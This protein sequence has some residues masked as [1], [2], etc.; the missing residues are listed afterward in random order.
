MS[1]IRLPENTPVMRKDQNAPEWQRYFL[2]I[3]NAC[4]AGYQSVVTADRPTSGLWDGRICW[5]R[6]L[7]KPIW[8]DDTAG[9]W[10]DATGTPV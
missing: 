2:A 4:F 8:W 5:D 9:V 10:V 6:T 1:L 3:Y 7:G